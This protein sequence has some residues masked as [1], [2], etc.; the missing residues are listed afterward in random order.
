PRGDPRG[1]A[2][3]LFG[4]LRGMEK[5]EVDVIV[6]EALAEEGIGRAVMDR[7]RKAATKIIRADTE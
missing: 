7:L 3:R 2:E 5:K 6:V 4:V 1:A